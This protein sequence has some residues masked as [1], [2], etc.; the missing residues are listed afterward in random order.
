MAKVL[1]LVRGPPGS[2]K[3]T[4]AQELTAQNCAA[5]MFFEKEGE[6]RFDPTKL[7]EAHGWCQGQVETWMGTG[8]EKI[9]VHN[10]FTQNW[11]MQPYKLLAAKHG[12]SVFVIVC[13]NDFGDVHGV[14][15]EATERMKA[16]W[17]PNREI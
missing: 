12:Y 5:D 17:E 15:L 8:E 13:E 7:G 14:P 1:Y 4:L 11:E 2:G 6:Y 16:R 9:A 3:T 10:T